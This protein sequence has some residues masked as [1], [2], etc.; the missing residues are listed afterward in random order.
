MQLTVS[1]ERQWAIHFNW[2]WYRT[3]GFESFANQRSDNAVKWHIDG[4]DYFWAV[5]ELLAV[6]IEFSAQNSS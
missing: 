1:I 5:S 4:H 2:N 3:I 6:S